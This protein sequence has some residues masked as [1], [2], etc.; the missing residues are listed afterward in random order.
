MTGAQTAAQGITY[1]PGNY[2]WSSATRNILGSAP[3][4]GAELWEVDSD[5]IG[6]MAISLGGYYASRCASRDKRFM[7][8]V[9]W[10][11]I[12]DYHATRKKRVEA[13][14]DT[15]LS[16]PGHHISWVTEKL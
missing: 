12:W 10:G 6:I 1:F 9:A 3:V 7:A 13:A 5:R 11:A 8:C 4:E 2:R 16:V 15:A 14:F